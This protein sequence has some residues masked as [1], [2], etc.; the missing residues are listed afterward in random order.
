MP[1]PP[2]TRG[3]AGYSIQTR[4]AAVRMSL[5]HNLNNARIANLLGV[6]RRKTIRRWVDRFVA[7]G[8][9]RTGFEFHIGRTG[10]FPVMTQ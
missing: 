7:T 3:T 1:P 5:V 8:S 10:V 9:V 4:E 2:S 6:A